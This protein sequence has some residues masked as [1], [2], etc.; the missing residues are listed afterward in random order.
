[1]RKLSLFGAIFVIMLA[2][3]VVSIPTIRAADLIVDDFNSQ[4]Q[5][6]TNKLNNLNRSISWSM[7][8]CYYGSDSCGNIIMN[9]SPT[10]QYY[11][12]NINQSIASSSSL[13]LR[14]RDWSDT[15]TENHWNIILNDG[16]DHTVGP[17]STYG[18]VTGSYTDITIPL[19]AFNANL[20]NAKYL[21]IV[22]RDATY[23][24]LMIDSIKFSGS[25][26]TPTP[27]PI[28]T[29]TP[30]PTPTVAATP[31]PT[32]AATPTPTATVTPTAT[33]TPTPT[34]TGTPTPTPA[35]GGTAYYEA[36]ASNNTLSGAAVVASDSNCS[37][38]K[39]VGY[40]GNGANNYVIFNGI[41]VTSSGSYTLTIYYLSAEA[42]TFDV[43]VNGGTGIVV[44]CNSSGGWSTVGTITATISLNS[45]NNTIKFY[46]NSGYCPDLDRISITGGGVVTPTP[47][48][49]PVATATPTPTVGPT[50]T[51]TPTPVAT[52]TPTPTGPTVTPTPKPTPSS[53]DTLTI[54]AGAPPYFSSPQ[55]DGSLAVHS[56]TAGTAPVDNP[57]KGIL[58]W[59]YHCDDPKNKP[60]PY[61]LE[62]H[63][64]GLGD[65]MTG[66][67][68][69]NWEPMEAY[70][71]EVASHG[72]QANF[73]V[74]TNISFGGQDIPAFLSDL[75][76]TDGN[77]PYDNPR[78]VSAFTNFARAL[79]AKYDGDPRI[80]F[81]TMG[82]IGKWGEWHTWPYEGGSN[83][84]PNLMAS[85]ATCNAVI[86]AY[87]AAFTITPLEIR[88]AKLGGGTHLTTLG[89]IGYHDDSF[90]YREGDPNLNNQ[91]LSM[92][93]PMS[94]SGKSDSFVQA[95]LN[96]GAENKWIT[97]SIGGEVR[98]EIQGQFTSPANQTK[99]DPVTDIQVA[100][101]TWMMCNQA[102]WTTSDTASMD[103]LR[104]FGYTFTV[105]NSYFNNSVSGSM[106]VGVKIEN[107]GVAPFYYGPNM[108]PVIVGLK[109]ASGN[110]VATW[111]TDW[112]LKKIKP[113]TIRAL[114]DWN[115]PGN[116]TFINMADPY[117]FDTTVSLSGVAHGAYTLVMRVKNPLEIYTKADFADHCDFSWMCYYEPKK[118]LFANAEQ[119][120]D[121]WL[122]LGS[123]QVN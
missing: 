106:K 85:D 2:I 75:P 103:V 104:N 113:S 80:G 47:T 20:A 70:L 109:D 36:E 81:I 91:I 117:Y 67:D 119:N 69:Y 101:A 27:T 102:A 82:L 7:D 78:V 15:D 34:A 95:M 107:T 122:S 99:D 100:H 25:G 45:G 58:Y 71:D 43:S 37:G 55:P 31:T 17:L 3:L 83:G 18:N 59:W 14:L 111:T 73:R 13:V 12:E 10:G 5:W 6:V 72:H 11:Q 112:N 92:T 90:C 60:T 68:S 23:A 54:P 110:V 24:V 32:R 61:S 22:H 8:S 29:S 98:P 108:W 48:P 19:S 28:P 16:S 118:L 121:G 114:P 74:S 49:T 94:M 57:L 76:T 42:R 62:W 65:L 53:D 64:F 39:K 50:N 40:L 84:N 123:I 116:P 56:L 96:N 87:N 51:P 1:M 35:G 4:T 120:S 38:G 52:A 88:Y 33:A 105:R 86:D 9:S 30:T 79:G 93:L 115:L 97:G 21:R 89:R 44:N 46:N 77:L 66:P 63:Y 41:N 26:A